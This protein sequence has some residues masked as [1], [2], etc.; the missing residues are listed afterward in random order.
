MNHVTQWKHE[1]KKKE[2]MK[3]WT[4]N[5]RQIWFDL[6]EIYCSFNIIHIRRHSTRIFTLQNFANLLWLNVINF[7]HICL[8][9][10]S[11][12]D[13]HSFSRS[14]HVYCWLFCNQ[15]NIMRSIVP[16]QIAFP[17]IHTLCS[18]F[19]R[20]QLSQCLFLYFAV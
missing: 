19:F 14:L 18:S 17:I 2:N 20:E 12:T 7:F 1:K 16:K 6:R 5:L 13:F 8:F 11:F 3:H 9:R 10:F 4:I 15:L